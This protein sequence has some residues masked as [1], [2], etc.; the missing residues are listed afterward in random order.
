MSIAHALCTMSTATA[1]VVGST[2]QAHAAGAA[3]QDMPTVTP[4]SFGAARAASAGCDGQQPSRLGLSLRRPRVG[5][6]GAVGTAEKR[7]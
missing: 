1:F 6:D 3:S 7:R 4:E 2:G 5:G